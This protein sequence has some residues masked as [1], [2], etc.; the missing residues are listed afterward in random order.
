[1]RATADELQRWDAH[2]SVAHIV[3]RPAADRCRHVFPFW[4]RPSTGNERWKDRHTEGY[5]EPPPWYIYAKALG[6]EV[7]FG[8]TLVGMFTRSTGRGRTD[9]APGNVVVDTDAK[10]RVWP[11]VEGHITGLCVYF[12][13][14][15]RR[16]FSLTREPREREIEN[17]ASLINDQLFADGFLSSCFN[18]RGY[19]ILHR[20]LRM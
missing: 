12:G 6:H 9:T 1:V 3:G 15:H 8:A 19:T 11:S 2:K 13:A 10:K 7:Y 14:L 17:A 16:F 4:L 18:L 20:K 5:G